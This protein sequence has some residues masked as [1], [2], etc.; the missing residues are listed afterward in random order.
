MTNETSREAR[1]FFTLI[2]DGKLP[3]ARR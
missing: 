3:E 2:A 1:Y